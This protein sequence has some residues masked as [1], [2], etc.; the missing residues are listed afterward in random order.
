M[1]VREDAGTRKTPICPFFFF[2]PRHPC[3]PSFLLTTFPEK[4]QTLIKSF[5]EGWKKSIDQIDSD[6]MRSFPNFKVGLKM[7]KSMIF[8]RAKF[9]ALFLQ[10][11]TALL[12]FRKH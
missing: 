9:A 6:V 3:C 8:E 5:A 12:F 11:R 4:I 2:S 7:L 10:N 1:K